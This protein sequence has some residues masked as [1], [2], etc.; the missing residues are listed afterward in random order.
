MHERSSE[1]NKLKQR[2]FIVDDHAI[3]RDGLAQLI[4]REKDLAVCG[5]A[6]NIPDAQQAVAECRPDAVIV[7]LTLED[8][9]GIRLIEHLACSF[10]DIA[11][12]VFSMHDE[13]VYAERCLKA[14]ARGYIMKQESPGEIISALRKVLSGKIYLSGSLSEKYLDRLVSRKGGVPVSSVELLSNR[15]LEIYQLIGQGMKKREISEKLNLSVKTVE[16]YM[17]HIKKKM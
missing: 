8:G 3:V 16:N 11:I 13:S 6:G 1:G 10:K 5:G 4:N 17:E 14:G 12:L 7:D 9:N 15:E 2:V